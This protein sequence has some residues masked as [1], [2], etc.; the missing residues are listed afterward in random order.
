[1]KYIL[2]LPNQLFENCILIENYIKNNLNDETFKNIEIILYE[3]PLYFTKF[4]YHKMKLVMHRST[5]KYYYNY[6]ITNYNINKKNI[7][8][9]DFHKNFANKI[10]KNDEIFIY[11]PLDHEILEEINSLNCIINIIDNPGHICDLNDFDEYR[12]SIK[13]PFMH[14]S[15]YIWF[16]KK[17]N[18]LM[19]NEKPL[20]NKWSFDKENRLSFP[21]NEEDKINGIVNDIIKIIIIIIIK[22]IIIKIIII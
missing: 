14:H 17:Y 15:F 2:I 21:K 6:L 9:I 22:I 20:G 8:Y 5:M 1:M 13:N 10:K 7:S 11:N 18:I 12:I 19:N 4:T 16:R 3:H